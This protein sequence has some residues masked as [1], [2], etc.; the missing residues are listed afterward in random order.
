MWAASLL[1]ALAAQAADAPAVPL[2]TFC[3]KPIAVAAER[4]H[5]LSPYDAEMGSYGKL[6]QV[7]DVDRCSDGLLLPWSLMGLAAQYRLFGRPEDAL[8]VDRV[9]LRLEEKALAADPNDAMAKSGVPQG[10]YFILLDRAALGETEALED[11][12][13]RDV[14]QLD[15]GHYAV[16]LQSDLVNLALAAQSSGSYVTAREA[17]ERLLKD[18]K[19]QLTANGYAPD[20][21]AEGK[22]EAAKCM[23]L[24]QDLAVRFRAWDAAGRKGDAPTEDVQAA[25]RCLGI[26]LRPLAVLQVQWAHDTALAVIARSSLALG[27]EGEARKALA[28]RLMEPAYYGRH[29]GETELLYATLLKSGGAPAW[30][31]LALTAR[32]WAKLDAGI[33]DPEAAYQGQPLPLEFVMGQR[34][35]AGL[36]ATV[37]MRAGETELL[38]DRPEVALSFFRAALPTTDAFLSHVGL[39]RPRTNALIGL[40]LLETNRPADALP[41]LAEASASYD[42]FSPTSRDARKVQND[43]F[44]GAVDVHLAFLRA[45]LT[46]GDTTRI[47][48]ALLR[49]GRSPLSRSALAALDHQKDPAV[50]AAQDAARDA[51]NATFDLQRAIAAGVPIARLHELGTAASAA[52]ARAA[53]RLAMALAGQPQLRL[54]GLGQV[55]PMPSVQR[56]LP[57]HAALLVL[58]VGRDRGY[59]GLVTRTS[60]TCR[61]IALSRSKLAQLIQRLRDS[62]EFHETGGSYHVRPFDYA[63]AGA[64]Y[65]ALIV[66]LEPEL[67][68]IT[69]LF[70]SR[71]APFDGIP[72]GAL[73]DE[74]HHRWLVDRF[75]TSILLDPSSL[76]APP[77]P[78]VARPST[79]LAIG[80]PDLAG[81][82]FLRRLTV[83]GIA[84]PATSAAGA[85]SPPSGLPGAGAE[86]SAMLAAYPASGSRVLR[87]KGATEARF[88]QALRWPYETI[89][90]ATHAMT[91]SLPY[92]FPEPAIVLT[93]GHPGQPQDDG[94]LHADE[95]EALHVNADMVILSA[96]E[97]GAGNGIPGAET[98]SG[99]AQSFL[100][101]GAL[102]VLAT[103]WSVEST[104]AGELTSMIV[105][106]RAAMPDAAVRLQRAMIAVRGQPARSHPA[107]WAPFVLVEAS[108]R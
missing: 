65:R 83:D 33:R 6:L 89:A 61:P 10:H 106:N 15:S 44:E 53:D 20:E 90:I 93:P 56:H 50:K 47:G 29:G 67:T 82:T 80:D 40:A 66:P 46:M 9:Y 91:V 74:A 41:L 63:D 18:L 85:A 23:A 16:S 22:A 73:R 55:A 86:L 32:A 108:G 97:T 3:G 58:A 39:I 72:F 77:P 75:A 57:D 70:V 48:E 81:A 1:L 25:T 52:N 60:V 21:T 71:T 13:A 94:L 54:F 104:S 26:L 59:V 68:G 69:R 28:I 92:R 34:D 76:A 35:Q 79:V 7:E 30:H 17:A 105:K 49:A 51:S 38:L 88:R 4:E 2:P 64:L 14:A 5:A 107:F 24:Q 8:R 100:Y 45:A 78:E 99:L 42:G 101:A 12:I 87:G 11:G 95:I 96:C 19:P 43:A 84:R 27:D 31:D 98:L 37:L 103:Q 36:S 62:S 102:N